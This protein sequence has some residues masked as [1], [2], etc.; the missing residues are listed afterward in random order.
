MKTFGSPGTCFEQMPAVPGLFDLQKW[1]MIFLE[2]GGEGSEPFVHEPFDPRQA[3]MFLLCTVQTLRD[4]RAGS[5][6]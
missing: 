2:V 1:L 5:R 4:Y 6:L 3:R